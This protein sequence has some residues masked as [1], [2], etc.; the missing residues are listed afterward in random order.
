MSCSKTPVENKRPGREYTVLLGERIAR[1]ARMIGGKR[2]LALTAG[3]KE[4]QIYRYIGGKN[5]PG[6]DV[7]VNISKA[8][9]VNIEWLSTGE[10]PVFPSDLEK[11][12]EENDSANNSNQI[13]FYD[14]SRQDDF[15]AFMA[16]RHSGKYHTLS[17]PWISR[18]P[19]VPR[20]K[21]AL[22]AATG[23]AMEPAIMDGSFLLVDMSQH[24]AQDGCIFIFGLDN[25]VIIRRIQCNVNGGL[26]LISDNKFYEKQ[27]VSKTDSMNIRIMGK[28][29]LT[30]N[31]I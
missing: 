6:V 11:T 28:I 4:N 22:V 25:T 2:K 8:A 20:E 5:I 9:G 18:L 13:P 3:V 7:L 29:I 14:I 24:I 1:V 23:D 30:A 12:V 15:K 16:D 10:G 19:T 26:F 27:V 17:A 21:L 31:P